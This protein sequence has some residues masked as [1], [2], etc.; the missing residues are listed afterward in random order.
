[1]KDRPPRQH[2]QALRFLHYSPHYERLMQ[3]PP[4][5]TGV[6]SV[7]G[8]FPKIHTI[9]I[10]PSDWREADYLYGSLSSVKSRCHP[11]DGVRGGVR[12]RLPS[13]S[14]KNWA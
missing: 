9:I 5:V 12:P 7:F 10:V 2:C 14:Q 1:M 3:Q 8:D 11:P 4:R 13:G 6:Q